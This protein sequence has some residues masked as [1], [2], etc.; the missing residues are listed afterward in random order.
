[1]LPRHLHLTYLLVCCILTFSY[2]GLCVFTKDGRRS[3]QSQ[4]CSCW[5]WLLEAWDCPRQVEGLSVDILRNQTKLLTWMLILLLL[6]LHNLTYHSKRNGEEC[7]QIIQV[8]LHYRMCL[9][10]CLTL[11]R[12][13]YN[14]SLI[15]RDARPRNSCRARNAAS[16][17]RATSKDNTRTNHS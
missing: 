14:T 6:S 3:S 1:M 11:C 9:T 4:T 12:G 7:R 8:S 5:G 15:R 17:S 10:F 16:T 2:A 13:F